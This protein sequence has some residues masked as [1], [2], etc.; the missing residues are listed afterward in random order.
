[1][2][3][4]FALSVVV[5]T[6]GGRTSVRDTVEA[7][8]AETSLDLEV[9]VV[10]DG[11]SA[12]AREELSSIHDDRLRVHAQPPSGPSG[13]RN[14]GLSLA[15]H[16]WVAFVDDDDI[17][18]PRWFETWASHAKDSDAVITA[19]LKR[20]QGGEILSEQ[21]CCVLDEADPTMQASRLLAGA[22]IVR[23]EVLQAVGGY[24][25][26]LRF[27][28]NQDLGLRLLDHLKEAGVVNAV[29]SIDETVIDVIMEKPASRQVR[30]GTNRAHAAKVLQ[31]RYPARL[32]ADPA[33]AAALHRIIAHSALERG[34]LAEFR[35]SALAA[36]RTQPMRWANWRFLLAAGAPGLAR[37]LSQAKS[38]LINGVVPPAARSSTSPRDK[39][40][41]D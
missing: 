22:F 32:A 27:S 6:H 7:L 20:W 17:P 33:H 39:E 31:R 5:P 3:Q 35:R 40:I 13:A 12:A 2:V 34:H 24:D 9:I 11:E 14:R 16:H 38:M 8:L 23:R 18:R 30:Y 4:P 1:M 29:R 15:R 19:C 41:H 10:C 21:H 36:V 28:E 26:N 25:P 37:V